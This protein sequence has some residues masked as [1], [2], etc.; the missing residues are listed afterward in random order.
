MQPVVIL[1]ED[2]PL[3]EAIA[4]SGVE[5]HVTPVAKITRATFGLAALMRLIGDLRMVMRQID[6]IVAGRVVGV[7]HSNTLAVIGGAVWAWRRDRPHLWHVHEI[8][9][10]PA[11]VRWALPWL[12]GRLSDRL[13]A[14]STQT[15]D[16]L[17]SQV[18]GLALCTDVVFNGLPPLP[19]TD[20]RAEADFRRHIRASPTHVV[21]TLA[22]RLNHWKGQGLLVE[23]VDRLRQR[24]Q[25][26]DLRVALVGD[27]VAGREG[28]VAELRSRVAALNLTE[29]IHFVG[30]TDDIY[31]V[32]RAS[33]IAVVASTEP[34]PFGMVAIE[35]MACGLPVV[36]AAHGGLLDIVL[37]NETGLLFEP[38][39]ADALADALAV[40]AFDP[41]LR[42]RQGEAG[43]SRQK[44][45]FSID[46]Q[47]TRT[48]AI[49]RALVAT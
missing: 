48:L 47:A 25:L 36:A 6:R 23:A 34:E 8:I 2:G 41:L 45:L 13:I 26:G 11:L 3:R 14:N 32:W 21:V 22:G 30:F 16:W 19:H 5:V 24:G 44:R 37:Q 40:L 9:M 49:Q 33:A 27:A 29:C 20:E 7:V 17:V 18:P 31:S 12:A 15:R 4:A 28:V 39:S 35:A 38:G 43:L 10:R 46:R 1:N 42:Q